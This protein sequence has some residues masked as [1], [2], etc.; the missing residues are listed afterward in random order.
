MLRELNRR[1]KTV[2]TIAVSAARASQTR[3]EEFHPV[4]YLPKPFAIEALLRL[5]IGEQIAESNQDTD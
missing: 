3:L 4:A 2:P 1:G 5:V